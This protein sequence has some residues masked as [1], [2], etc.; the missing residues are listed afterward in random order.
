[1]ESHF[2]AHEWRGKGYSVR[3]F[4]CIT[5][6][7]LFPISIISYPFWIRRV[8][9]RHFCSLKELAITCLIKYRRNVSVVFLLSYLVS[10]FHI[11]PLRAYVSLYLFP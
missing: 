4:S 10:S 8:S 7:I 2:K 5:F 3:L 9:E 11:E 1:M 6:F